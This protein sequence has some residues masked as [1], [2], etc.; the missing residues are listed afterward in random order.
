MEESTANGA[1]SPPPSDPYRVRWAT[2]RRAALF[3]GVALGIWLYFQAQAEPFLK[4][5][6]IDFAIEQQKPRRLFEEDRSQMQ[7]GDYIADETQGKLIEVSG[8]DWLIFLQD[9][10]RWKV[11]AS[12]RE[13]W[14]GR[15]VRTDYYHDGSVYFRPHEEP[16]SL[17]SDSIGQDDQ[18]YLHHPDGGYARIY[19]NR[20]PDPPGF[21][22]SPSPQPDSFL[23]P[24]RSWVLWI[25]LIA[26]VLYIALPWPRKDPSIMNMSAG[27]L[28]L[29]DFVGGILFIPLF[30]MPSLIVG[31][32]VETITEGFF[33][34]L[35]M[36]FMAFF[37]DLIIYYGVKTEAFSLI[38]LEDRFRIT[39]LRLGNQDFLFSEIS[40]VEKLVQRP[41]KWLIISLTLAAPIAATAGTAA[42]AAGQAALLT[43]AACGGF[44]IRSRDGRSA[45]LWV[46]D[47]SGG[48]AFRNFD[49]FLK[50]LDEKGLELKDPPK[51]IR[52][53]FPP[54]V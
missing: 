44:R 10:Q 46:T 17:V 43:G 47:Q 13:D 53:F 22:T 14:S 28:L 50:V 18:L 51:E 37:G 20:N 42:T 16:L 24:F 32:S 26:V 11:D 36:W 3:G 29:M 52:A 7:L 35:V 2:V 48:I 25:L 49:R 8:Q 15:V 33:L 1:N 54:E 41:P 12:L 40:E 21:M 27:R 39:S 34:T 9:L 45:C 31:G 19:F 30:G 23:F 5:E 4:V 38:I 6:W